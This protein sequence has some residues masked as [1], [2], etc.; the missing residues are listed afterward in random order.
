[1]NQELVHS[2]FGTS[3][4]FVNAPLEERA[5]RLLALL[6]KWN[7]RSFHPRN[8]VNGVKQWYPTANQDA[9]AEAMYTAWNYLV[10]LDYLVPDHESVMGDWYVVSSK[11]KAQTAE[12][13]RVEREPRPS[14]EIPISS[15][16]D[17]QRKRTV[18]V[19]HGRNIK[20]KN[21]VFDLVKA[22]GLIPI[23]WEWAVKRT[24]KASPYVGEVLAAA[25]AHAQAII[26]LMSGDDEGRLLEK[27]TE[28]D[29]A[30]FETRLTPQARLNVVFE[31]GLAFGKDETRTILVEV[32]RLRPFSDIAGR[33]V[34]RFDGSEEKRR[35]LVNRLEIAQ[36]ILDLRSD[37]YLSMPLSYR[38]PTSRK[39]RK[40]SSSTSTGRKE[41]STKTKVQKRIPNE[42]MRAALESL[43]QELEEDDRRI[44]AKTDLGKTIGPFFNPV[45]YIPGHEQLSMA[46]WNALQRNAALDSC[47]PTI[48][49]L[50]A[51]AY[52]QVE[53]LI[54]LEHHFRDIQHGDR[55][56]VEQVRSD[57]RNYSGPTLAA[58]ERGIDAV[59]SVI[60]P[61]THSS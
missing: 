39:R 25:F 11:T 14:P 58:I 9:V 6:T 30:E 10:R 47:D 3:A 59:K 43:R 4:A 41:R 21:A 17:D 26:V 31:A 23:E 46:R 20:L 54:S 60:R 61:V 48:V 24:G 27:F 52:G 7:A 36:C 1:M 50:L 13:A 37:D 19:V 28:R 12:L 53:L 56:V 34:V 22:I 33:H 40:T 35:A 16:S 44:R 29:D 45:A 55:T 57:L 42:A 32:G 49:G 18:M 5:Q 51:D 38:F 8:V 15:S 2:I